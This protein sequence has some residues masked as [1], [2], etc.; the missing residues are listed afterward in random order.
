MAKKS[1]PVLPDMLEKGL[2]VVFCGT[3]AGTLSARQGH[4]YA[5]PQN[6]FWRTLHSTG[7]TP[8]R[9]EPSEYA[10]LLEWRI[11]LTD[12][13]KHVFGMDKELPPQSLGRAACEDLRARMLKFQPRILAFT[14]LAAGRSVLGPKSA[15]GEQQEKIGITRLWILPSPSPVAQWNWDED[16]WKDL[17]REIG[18][19][20]GANDAQTA[21]VNSARRSKLAGARSP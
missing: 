1:A 20:R 6:R 21:I 19:F 4:Y 17:A 15:L 14:S 3:A 9:L 18:A 5:H 2:A 11:G 7:L 12:I 10:R 8:Q 13:A 16:R